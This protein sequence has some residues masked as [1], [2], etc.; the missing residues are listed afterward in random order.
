MSIRKK[1]KAGEMG[2]RLRDIRE[3][4]GM[5]R[6]ALAEELEIGVNHLVKIDCGERGLTNLRCLMVKEILDVSI[7][8]LITG[9]GEYDKSVQIFSPE[10]G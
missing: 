7:H 6:A 5:S 3:A 9:R 4:K 2:K 1:I 10:S 8:Y